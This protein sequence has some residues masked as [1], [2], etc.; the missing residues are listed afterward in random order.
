M[1][2]NSSKM[3]F[4]STLMIGTITAISSSNWFGIWMG[5]EINLISFVPIMFKM[6]KTQ[7]SEAMM[8]YFLVQAMGS[9]ILLMA[10]IMSTSSTV[11][12]D[13]INYIFKILMASSL[14]LKLGSAPFHFWMPEVMNKID[15]EGCFMLSTWQKIAPLSALSYI[16][17]NNPTILIFAAAS[18]IVGA[19]GGLNETSLR[20]IMAYSSISHLGWMIAC[21]KVENQ[22]WMIYLLV[23]TLIVAT[24][25][26]TFNRLAAFY[27]N[28]LTMN[29]TIMEKLTIATIFLSMGGLPPFLGFMPKWMVIQSLTNYSMYMIII[30][31]ILTTLITLY[32]Y[33]RTISTMVLINVASCKWTMNKP[34]ST[35][36]MIMIILI[37]TAT[38]LVATMNLF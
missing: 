36:F 19:M 7:T 14:A 17:E 26:I 33:L 1:F 18:T 27:M 25:M 2:M 38:P 28:Q 5:L 32:Y 24:A 15:W 6:K 16:A 31:M 20:K 9:V 8:I 21:I 11:S 29:T 22:L 37:N 30:M 35:N 13:M 34:L 3:L 10:V 4:Y 23:Y 12:T